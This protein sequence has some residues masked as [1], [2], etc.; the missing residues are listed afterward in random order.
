[1]R[2]CSSNREVEREREILIFES[3][4]SLGEPRFHYPPS[5]V[6][7]RRKADVRERKRK[8]RTEEGKKKERGV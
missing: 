3:G 7:K 2:R 8:S 1:M 4:H 6:M 5:S